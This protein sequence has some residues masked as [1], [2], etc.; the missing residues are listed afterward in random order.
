MQKP[1]AIVTSWTSALLRQAQQYTATAPTQPDGPTR[2]SINRR[3][4]FRQVSGG[5]R[6]LVECPL[7][8]LN[9]GKRSVR[10]RPNYGH[11]HRVKSVRREALST[12]DI[13][14]E[15][16]PSRPRCKCLIWQATQL[17]TKCGRERERQRS[18][19]SERVNSSGQKTRECWAFQGSSAR[20]R[21]FRASYLAE[22]EYL[23]SNLLR[24]TAPGSEPT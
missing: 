7:P 13:T 5:N 22:G 12:R 8:R 19:A 14:R 15:L 10:F 1:T 24:V 23:G 4:E 17:R 18:L 20:R 16:N 3:S 2:G 11:P 6:P 9:G 21:W